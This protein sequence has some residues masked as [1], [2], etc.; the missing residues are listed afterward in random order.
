MTKHLHPLCTPFAP[1][2]I[3]VLCGGGLR[4][5]PIDRCSDMDVGRSERETPTGCE[6]EKKVQTDDFCVGFA[7]LTSFFNENESSDTKTNELTNTTRTHSVKTKTANMTVKHVKNKNGKQQ[8]TI[9]NK[10]CDKH[11]RVSW[12]SRH[13]V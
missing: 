13:K 11:C 9:P 2:L 3:V 4:A 1:P 6:D 10:A 5:W 7:R 12:L 8:K